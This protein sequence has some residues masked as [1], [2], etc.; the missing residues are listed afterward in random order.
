VEEIAGQQAISLSAQERSPGGV[1]VPRGRPAPAGAQDPPH[2]RFADLM[3]EL[4]QLTVDPAVSPG[5]VLPRQPQYQVAD[6]LAD[7]RPA[8][9]V[10]VRPLAGDQMAVPGQQRARS[11]EPMGT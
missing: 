5:R 3:S 11:D 4:A 10:R 2:G 6:L 8:R 1:H 9:P 7:G